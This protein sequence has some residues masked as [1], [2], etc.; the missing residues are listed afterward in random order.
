MIYIE[1][2]V[3]WILDTKN[4]KIHETKISKLYHPPRFEIFISQTLPTHKVFR[5]ESMSL[6]CIND[7]IKTSH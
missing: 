2:L 4:E 1:L 6:W 7:V 3:P 5:V